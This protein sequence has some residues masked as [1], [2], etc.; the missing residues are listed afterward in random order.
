MK[1]FSFIIPAVLL[2]A[3]CTNSKTEEKASIEHLYKPSYADNFKIGDA[4]NA[5]LVEQMHQAVLAKKFDEAASFLAD[6]AV[7]YLGDGTTIKGKP[8][9]LD[10]MQKQY[11]QVNIK[12]YEVQVNLPVVT[13]TG[14]EWVL[15]W[16]NADV[17]TPDGKSIKSNWMEA[18]HFKGGKIVGMNQFEKTEKA[19][20]K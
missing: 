6:T 18:F 3:A 10:L 11:S 20:T 2:I 13:E 16:D 19:E 4:K 5:L 15:L 8:A 7:F 1:K 17:E 14:E 9:I 12:N